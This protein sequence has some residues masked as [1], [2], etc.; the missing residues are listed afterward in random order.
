MH[1]DLKFRR[2]LGDGV[3]AGF[4]GYQ[5]V[6]WLEYGGGYGPDAIALEPP[7]LSELW[8][9]EAVLPKLVAEEKMPG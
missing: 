3:Y 1:E 5:I 6:I 8:Q 2:Y 9:Y 4:D 7:V